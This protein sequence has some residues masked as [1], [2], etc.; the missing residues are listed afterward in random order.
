MNEI[1]KGLQDY[2][3]EDASLMEEI[4]YEEFENKKVAPGNSDKSIS[5]AYQ[6]YQ[7][8]CANLQKV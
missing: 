5:E 7:K 6:V 4:T 8:Y 2:L 1:T 3:A